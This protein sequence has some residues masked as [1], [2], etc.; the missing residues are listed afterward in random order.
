MARPP[1]RVILLRHREAGLGEE[2]QNPLHLTIPHLTALAEEAGVGVEEEEAEAE[3]EVE[4]GRLTVVLQPHA[5]HGL[6]SQ[7]K[8]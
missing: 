3:V 5:L 6:K 1:L 8:S 4:E 7:K 2:T